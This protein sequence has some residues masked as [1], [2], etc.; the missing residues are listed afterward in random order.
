MTFAQPTRKIILYQFFTLYCLINILFK[1]NLSFRSIE[2]LNTDSIC[3]LVF[4]IKAILLIE[5]NLR[6]DSRNEHKGIYYFFNYILNALKLTASRCNYVVSLPSHID[7]YF[8]LSFSWF[9]ITFAIFKPFILLK[10]KTWIEYTKITAPL[11]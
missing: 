3:L 2:K 6:T 9:K 4:L 5:P 7:S 1:T 10:G 11:Y 8:T